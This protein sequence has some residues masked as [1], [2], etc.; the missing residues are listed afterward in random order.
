[1]DLVIEQEEEQE[2]IEFFDEC[3]D[4]EVLDL[5]QKK[6]TG[7]KFGANKGE[8]IYDGISLWKTKYSTL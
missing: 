1:M 8:K 4:D 7:N 3:F 6:K 5:R 2:C